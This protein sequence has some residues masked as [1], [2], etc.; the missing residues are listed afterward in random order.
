M[1]L[2]PIMKL[3]PLKTV[4]LLIF[5]I[6]FIEMIIMFTID[7]LEGAFKSISAAIWAISDP[8]ALGVLLAPLIYYMI[9]KPLHKQNEALKRQAEIL[10]KNERL[11]SIME[12]IPDAVALRDSEGR[13]TVANGAALAML[14]LSGEDWKGMGA[15]ELSKKDGYGAFFG[16]ERDRWESSG[17]CRKSGAEY[18]VSGQNVDLRDSVGNKA[19]TVTVVRDVS[20]MR[21]AE[22]ELRLAAKAFETDEGIIITDKSNKIIRVNKAFTKL[23]GFEFEDVKGKN[24]SVFKSGVHGKEFYE[25]MW[26]E[27]NTMGCWQGEVIDKRK[28]GG[29]YPKWLTITEVRGSDGEVSNYVGI[30]SDITKSKEADR[31]IHQLAFYDPLTELPNRRFF[32]EK[33]ERAMDRAKSSGMGIALLFIDLDNFKELNDTKGHDVGDL[34]LVEIATR[35]RACIGGYD[36]IARFGGDEFVVLLEDLVGDEEKKKAVAEAVSEQILSAISMIFNLNDLNYYCSS[37][38]GVA[39]YDGGKASQEDLLKMAD[40][41]MYRAKSEGKNAIRLFDPSMSDGLRRKMMLT[42]E[43]RGALE[44]GELECHLQAQVSD[45]RPIGAEILLR[46][47][48]SNHGAISPVEFIPIAE[49]TGMIVP[50]GRWVLERACMM[51]KKWENKPS[52]RDLRLAVNVSARQ[53]KQDGFVDEVKAIVASSGIDPSKLELEITESLVLFDLEKSA[54]KMRELMAFGMSFS[55]DDFGTGQSSLSYLRKLP[56]D[57]LKID[58][59]FVMDVPEDSNASVIVKTIIGMARNLGLNVVAEGVETDG[60]LEFLKE[61]GCFSYQGYLFAKPMSE[62][63]FERRFLSAEAVR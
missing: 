12:A 33:I 30:F 4:V 10:S 38:I 40:L 21:E 61:Q 13:L 5:L 47:R 58:K 48:N 20:K 53:F 19:G 6:S 29:A 32:K 9:F 2:V 54:E 27:I 7:D 50:I 62:A 45:G 59:S 39:I 44:A 28:D 42:E 37:S 25:R 46:W 55:L 23:T 18:V 16:A 63:D 57:K 34:L 22:A 1:K 17:A 26:H 52:A 24:P 56:L 36:A 11:E 41:A 31:K 49:E 35:L 51:L 14:G 8:I 15:K 3:S 43:L 60:Q